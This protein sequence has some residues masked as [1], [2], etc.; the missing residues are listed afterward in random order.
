M[1]LSGLIQAQIFPDEKVNRGIGMQNFPWDKIPAYDM[2]LHNLWFT[3]PA[4][5]RE[6]TKYL[7]ARTERGFLYV[8]YFKSSPG[9]IIINTRNID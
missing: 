1:V 2:F 3:S 5:Y 4:A 6:A 8:V 7:P 9:N